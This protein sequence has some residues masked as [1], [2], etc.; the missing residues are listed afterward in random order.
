MT[1]KQ[2]RAEAVQWK[3]QRAAVGVYRVDVVKGAIVVTCK[4][5]GAT[6]HHYTPGEAMQL[7]AEVEGPLGRFQ[8]CGT[9][10][11]RARLA[12]LLRDVAIKLYAGEA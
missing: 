4:F 3:V 1:R 11:E 5:H 2:T 7:A 10:G 6:A 8:T 12:V 9:R